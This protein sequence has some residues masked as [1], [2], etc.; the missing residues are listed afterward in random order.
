MLPT[1]FQLPESVNKE[2][3]YIQNQDYFLPVF[4]TCVFF[5]LDV[6]MHTKTAKF[7]LLIRKYQREDEERQFVIVCVRLRSYE[8][9]PDE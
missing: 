3:N 5:Y 2:K 1:G 7:A 8:L 9:S 6:V 4:V